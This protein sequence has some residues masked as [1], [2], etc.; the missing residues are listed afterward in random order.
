MG[1]ESR[2][3]RRSAPFRLCR[4]HARHLRD[5]CGPK[6]MSTMNRS[7]LCSKFAV[8]TSL[9]LERLLP[10]L[11]SHRVLGHRR[12]TRQGR[13]RHHRRGRDLRNQN[14]RR[15]LGINAIAVS[16]APCSQGSA[17]DGRRR[18]PHR[19]R[20][21]GRRRRRQAMASGR[22]SPAPPSSAPPTKRALRATHRNSDT[23]FHE[24]G[25]D[26]PTHSRE[27]LSDHG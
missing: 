19:L 5:P 14:P 12:R 16:T 11:P 2:G 24:L 6:W 20:P 10:S 26:R 17:R 15:A 25:L 8:A 13:V 7:D 3:S 21:G 9:Y 23:L 22:A 18:D 4:T 1:A 27:R